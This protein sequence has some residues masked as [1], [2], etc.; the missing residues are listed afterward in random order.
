MMPST[1]ERESDFGLYPGRLWSLWEV[2]K[3]ADISGLVILCKEMGRVVERMSREDI[4]DLVLDDETKTTYFDVLTGMGSLFVEIEFTNSMKHITR[5]ISELNGR[6]TP[7]ELKPLLSELYNRVRDEAEDKY[8]IVVKSKKVEYLQ[9][10]TSLFGVEFQ[11][12][13]PSAAF[14]LEEA[15]RCFGLDRPTASVFH[16]MRVMEIGIGAVAR[17]LE[18]PDPIKPAER[19]WGVILKK[20][21]TDGIEKKWPTPAHRAIGDG[22]LFES[23]HASLDAVKNPW[24]NGTMH[25]E[26][27]YTDEEAEHIFAAVKGFMK[28]LASRMDENG[29]PKA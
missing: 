8:F 16:L 26:N 4:Q 20:I 27:K 19:N 24:R 12:K 9:Q 11:S 14:E 15:A 29:E 21:W 28:K 10:S 6:I 23:I 13:F 18:I 7:K 2:M 5:I 25:V 1:A 22:V 17:C 3:N